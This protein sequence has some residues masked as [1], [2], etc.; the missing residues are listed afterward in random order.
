MNVSS[1][2][3][4]RLLLYDFPQ[5][6]DLDSDVIFFEDTGEIREVPS[7]AQREP[8]SIPMFQ[9]CIVTTNID[10]NMIEHVFPT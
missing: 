3:R 6:D 4:A 8:K 2:K 5:D 1:N 7:Y 9:L 10:M